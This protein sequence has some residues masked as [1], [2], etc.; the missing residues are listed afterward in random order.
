MAKTTKVVIHIVC[1]SH[2][3]PAMAIKPV[4]TMLQG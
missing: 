1:S 3:L 2:Q 4:S